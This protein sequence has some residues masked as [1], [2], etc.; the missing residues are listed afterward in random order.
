MSTWHLEARSPSGT[1]TSG[2]A[3]S[4]AAQAVYRKLAERGYAVRAV[5]AAAALLSVSGCAALP[6][7]T[8]RDSGYEFGAVYRLNRLTGSVTICHPRYGC[9]PV[10]LPGPA[11]QEPPR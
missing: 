3:P 4:A 9:V 1:L 5:L 2:S 7:E 8:A 11:T 10:V 6:A